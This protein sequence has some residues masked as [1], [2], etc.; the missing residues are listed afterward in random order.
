MA[1]P[2]PPLALRVLL[3]ASLAMSVLTAGHALHYAR[4]WAGRRGGEPHASFPRVP[5]FRP[6]YTDV[7]ARLRETLPADARV[8]VE[9][10]TAP[11]SDRTRF[12]TRWYLPLAHDLYPREIYV[13]RPDAA[14]T[15]FTYREWLDHHF[16]VLDLDGSGSAD[17]NA[18]AIAAE[19]RRALL[20][21]D[22]RWR[23][24]I[25]WPF[26]P[27][28]VALDRLEGEEWVEQESFRR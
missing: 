11:D 24:R 7:L 25:P 17:V 21:R 28:S 12:P 13:R 2:R 23:L 4:A 27:G 6:E 14:C 1:S 3:G 5:W 20:A 15:F 18:A 26:D 22:I 8:L 9:P 19:E 10:S 16:E